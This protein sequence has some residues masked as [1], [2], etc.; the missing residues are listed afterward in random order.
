MSWA[1]VALSILGALLTA[2]A[3]R[4]PQVNRLAGVSFP[5]GWLVSELPVHSLVLQLVGTAGF[6]AAGAFDGPPAPAAFA[7]LALAGCS[8]CGLV[9][10]AV[11]GARARRIF[12]EIL[13]AAEPPEPPPVPAPAGVARL[14]RALPTRPRSV[15]RIRDVDFAGDGKPFHRLDVFRRRDAGDDGSPRPVLLYLHGGAWMIG[16]KREQG[17]PMMHHLAEQGAVCFTANYRLSPRA[18][19]PAHLEDCRQALDWVREHAP[20]YG[21]DPGR[22][23]L[24]GGSA[25]GH[26]ASLL[27]LS[28]AGP[29]VAGCLSLY[30]VYDF[31]DAETGHRRQLLR[32]LERHVMKQLRV[33][34]AAVYSEASPRAHVH[35][36]APPFLVVHGRN[37]TL[38][39]VPTARAFVAALRDV[40]KVPVAYVEL[41]FTQHAFDLFWSPRVAALAAAAQAF[42]FAR[43]STA[44]QP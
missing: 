38:V 15:E 44:P 34:Q 25:G 41:P 24:A 19:W 3:L 30:G 17:L 1:F 18:T 12:D 29:P 6:A 23:V 11:S 40:S 42:L 27:A 26:L 33:E 2:N 22:I 36:D 35:A 32:L 39:P 9:V 4:P 16:D 14:V 37:D 10:L 21:G 8:W 13:P 20:D 43:T 5:L 28:P 31:T 7:G